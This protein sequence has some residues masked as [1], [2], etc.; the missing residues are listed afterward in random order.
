MGKKIRGKKEENGWEAERE[1]K[2][3]REGKGDLI[4]CFERSGGSL[5]LVSTLI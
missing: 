1:E 3:G 5:R 4:R 2:K